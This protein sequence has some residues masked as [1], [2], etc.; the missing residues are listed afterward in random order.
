MSLQLFIY[1]SMEKNFFALY[2]NYFYQQ[3]GRL[4]SHKP[5]NVLLTQKY[6]FIV[7]LSVDPSDEVCVEYQNVLV[8]KINEGKNGCISELNMT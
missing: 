7:V 6:C 2:Q 3:Y 8:E 1:P 5:T 4:N